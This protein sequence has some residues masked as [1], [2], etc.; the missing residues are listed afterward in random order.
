MLQTRCCSSV[1]GYR[2]GDPAG[3]IRLAARHTALKK[4]RMFNEL[5]A[6]RHRL[7][8]TEALAFLPVTVAYDGQVFR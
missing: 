1:R 4:T 6:N 5:D 7:W 3:E 2:D 8:R